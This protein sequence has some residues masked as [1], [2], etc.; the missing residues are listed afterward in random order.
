MR[1][2]PPSASTC[3]GGGA[4]AA[5]SCFSP[6][7]PINIPRL[8]A[9]AMSTVGFMNRPKLTSRPKAE[10]LSFPGRICTRRDERFAYCRAWLDGAEN[11]A[12]STFI[13]ASTR[14]GQSRGFGV[15]CLFFGL[16]DGLHPNHRIL[17]HQYKES[18]L[19]QNEA[20]RGA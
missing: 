13:E 5:L 7:Q 20:L 11:R 9:A 6:P 3:T 16:P 17:F 2:T 14:T 19:Q 10:F 1:L 8:R 18:P 12:G 15:R 4:S